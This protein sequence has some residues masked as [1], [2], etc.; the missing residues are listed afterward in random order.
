MHRA[1]QRKLERAGWRAGST[2]DFLGLTAQ[3]SA[4]VEMRIALA[5][6]LRDA[7]ANARMTQFE[8]ARCLGSSQS[9]VAKMEAGDPAVS[10]DLLIRAHIALGESRQTVGRTMGRR[11]ARRRKTPRTRQPGA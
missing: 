7:R 5:E 2:S 1:K 6:T 11:V 9:R 10:L 4:V 3:E 8:L